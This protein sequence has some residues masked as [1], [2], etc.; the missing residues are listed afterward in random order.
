MYM[1]SS[2]SQVLTFTTIPVVATILGGIFAALRPPGQRVRSFIQHFAAGVVFAAVA[3]ELLPDLHDQ[4]PRVVVLGFALGVGLM[5]AIQWGSKRFEQ[6]NATGAFGG[7]LGLLIMV[8]IDV[9]IDGLLI[10]V[11]FAAGTEQGIIITI[12]LTIELLFLG[13]AIAVEMPEAVSKVLRIGT[14]VGLAVILLIGAIIGVIVFGGLTGPR[15]A[16]VI[17]F[18]AAALLYLVTEELLVEAHEVPETLGSTGMFFVGFLALFV[19]E[20]F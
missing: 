20:M 8:S 19:I 7:V 13:L 16:I 4:T 10:G 12:A 9:L 5:L 15:L 18:G 11:A 14:T 2:L 17:A 1:A 6:T 3:G